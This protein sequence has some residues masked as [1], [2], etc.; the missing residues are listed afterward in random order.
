V[1]EFN[2]GQTGVAPA[3]VHADET[4]PVKHADKTSAGHGSH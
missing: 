4:P 1:Q 3:I 2:P